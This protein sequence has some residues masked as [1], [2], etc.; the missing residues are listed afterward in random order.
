[1]TTPLHLLAFALTPKFYSAEM[2][3]TPRRVPPY[4][5]AE[6]AS[7]YRA[8][9]KKIYQ[10]EETRNIVMREF[11]Q[12]LSAKNHDVVALNARYG[13][14]ADE[15]WYVHGQGSVYLQ[16]L[17][18]NLNSQ[19]QVLLQLS[20]IGVHTPSSTQSN[21][22]VWVQRKPRIWSTYT[23]TFVC[24]HIRTLNIVRV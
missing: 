15:W 3:A 19:L 1:M 7:G 22:I 10:D 5:D 2:L 13:M 8:A 21:I 14:D 9:F 20:G 4:R 18:I 16:P 17:A 12:F 24:C 23:P 6:V 11:G